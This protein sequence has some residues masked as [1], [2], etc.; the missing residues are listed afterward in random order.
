[1]NDAIEIFKEEVSKLQNIKKIE[2][3][4]KTFLEVLGIARREVPIGNLLGFF[5]DSR[6]EHGLA[7]L[8][9]R[10][11]FETTCYELKEQQQAGS[12]FSNRF[13][14]NESGVY[15]NCDQPDISEITVES[16]KLEDTTEDN[17]RI[18]ILI[19]AKKFIIVIEFKI[20]HVL[21]NQLDAY[22]R[23]VKDNYSKKDNIPVFFV[24]LTPWK[25]AHEDKDIDNSTFK[26]VVLSEFVSNVKKALTV[27]VKNKINSNYYYPFLMDFIQTVDNRRQQNDLIELL[28]ES[29][30]E[31]L[32]EFGVLST[33]KW[34]NSREL[35]ENADTKLYIKELTLLEKDIHRKLKAIDKGWKQKTAVKEVESCSSYRYKDNFSG[36][37]Q[38][39]TSNTSTILK[40]RLSIK[41]WSIEDWSAEKSI[42][43]TANFHTSTGTIITM[44]KQIK[45]RLNTTTTIIVSAI[46]SSD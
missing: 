36:Y 40:V 19:K 16:V 31:V 41:G 6:K 9:L 27:E 10:C 35:Q 13:L 1:M 22:E 20:N 21:N 11:L 23:H 39:G 25:K 29:G 3:T 33:N 30:K 15:T 2:K 18:D 34:L 42:E 44:V 17:L 4:K 37:V 28:K 7:D 43:A 38:I 32:K 8:F 46:N 26:H 45:Q 24:I 14:L 5:L 12:L